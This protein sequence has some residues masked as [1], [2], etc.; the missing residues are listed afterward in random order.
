METMARGAT[1]MADEKT[2]S[3][4]DV[5]AADPKRSET[6]AEPGHAGSK[7]T[8]NAQARHA[9]AAAGQEKSAFEQ[10]L[11]EGWTA[12]AIRAGQTRSA[13][14]VEYD[15][16]THKMVVADERFGPGGADLEGG[17]DLPE[18]KVEEDRRG[19]WLAIERTLDRDLTC[20]Y[21]LVGEIRA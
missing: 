17:E 3:K 1:K 9:Q 18:V 19:G 4:D 16:A 20:L 21:Q 7:H 2:W 5:K 15:P 11:A 6:R 10:K 12:L 14:D 8:P 13:H